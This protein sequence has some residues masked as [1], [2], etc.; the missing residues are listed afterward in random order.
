MTK[1]GMVPNGF[2]RCCLRILNLLRI[3]SFVL[4]ICSDKGI[5]LMMRYFKQFAWSS[6][7][8]LLLALGPLSLAQQRGPGGRIG[9]APGRVTG[10]PQMA[11]QPNIV[12]GDEITEAQ[13]AAVS[14]GLE[15]L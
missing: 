10:S 7:L 4:R 8:V 13:R 9:A 6:A 5:A 14:K 1:N 2:D 12:R 11:E 15:R 3:S